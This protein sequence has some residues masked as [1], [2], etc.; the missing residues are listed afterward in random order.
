MMLRT[1][2]DTTYYL[3][4][5]TYVKN[6]SKTPR[7]TARIRTSRITTSMR[8]RQPYYTCVPNQLTFHINCG[9]NISTILYRDKV[10][11]LIECEENDGSLSK[12][13]VGTIFNVMDIEHEIQ[14]NTITKKTYVKIYHE[15]RQKIINNEHN[16]RVYVNNEL[17]ID[18]DV[19]E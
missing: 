18:T 4:L 14:F 12:H 19:T 13:I 10:T 9:P 1:A 15:G 6:N 8:N 5:T 2:I 7:M 3:L 11:T 16:I 17:T